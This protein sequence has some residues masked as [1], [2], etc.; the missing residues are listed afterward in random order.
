MRRAVLAVL[1]S[2]LAGASAM[3]ALPPA[4]TDT[5]AWFERFKAEATDEELY[6]FLYAMPKGGDLHNHLSGSILS[7]W[8]YDLALQQA[9]RGYRYYTRVRIENC[10][11]YG[12]NA[13]VESPY[14]LMFVTIQESTFQALDA[15]EQSEYRPLEA[16]DAAQKQAWLDSLRLEKPW[17]GRDE[18]FET[19]WQRMGDLYRN[20]YLAADALLRNMQAFADEGL[21][22]LESMIGV[23]GFIDAGGADIAPDAVADIYRAALATEAA[24][25]TGVTVRLQ[26]AILRFLP[27]A[28]QHLRF[29]Y[30]FAFRHR[31]LF[32]AVNMVGREDNDKGYPLRF[33]STLR[34]L[35]RQYHSVRL[36]IHGGEVDE[37]N[38]HVRDTLLL[39]A[40][41]IGHGVNLIT[42]ADTMRL[43]RH[44]PYLVEINLVSNLLLQYVSDY[45][46]HP[47]PEYL[48]TG[49][50]V[51]LST[52]D[53][54]MWDSN[55]TDEFFVAVKEFNLSWDELVTLSRNSL[56]F[57]FAPDVVKADMLSR[58]AIRIDD[59]R[60][61]VA[62]RPAAALDATAHSYGFTCRRYGLCDW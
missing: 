32:V 1:L 40:D 22:Y 11:P 58:L 52:D 38:S 57:A 45:D 48:R 34:E 49:I 4:D 7:E 36:S 39:G 55:L 29:L 5:A 28:E 59:F 46:E 12:G 41:R 18:F 56:R 9:E 33:L 8:F 16:L 13:F 25:A 3:A 23:L 42:D 24:L 35:R 62:T 14:L 21:M 15:C 50:P 51:A 20:P 6:R 19:H 37:P 60:R 31:D 26:V 10:R 61:Q 2:L 53:R 30:D 43:M 54:G 27:D 47:F 17:E 44:G